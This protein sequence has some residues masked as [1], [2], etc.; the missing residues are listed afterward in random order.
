LL[1]IEQKQKEVT[2]F[3]KLLFVLFMYN[4]DINFPFKIDS[5]KLRLKSW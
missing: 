4:D 1:F 2:N 3:P 5:Q